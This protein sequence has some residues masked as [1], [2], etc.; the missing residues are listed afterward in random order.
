MNP[1][2]IGVN[3]IENDGYGPTSAVAHLVD[4]LNTA[5]APGTYAFIDVD[6][7]TSQVDA[8]G[9]DAIKVGL[10]YKPASVTPVGQTAALNTVAFVNGGDASP[11]NRASLAQAFQQNANGQV[12][13]VNVNHLK[14]K[15][16]ACTVPDAGD[17][18]G[19]CNVVRVNAVTEL[20]NWLAADPTGTGD[21]DILLVG[22]YNSYAMEDPIIA[23]ENGG[24]THLIKTLLGP[25]AYSYVF[26]G[27]WGY[28][29][30]A[31]GS[32]SIA[33]QISGV[34]DYHINSDEP[35]ALDYNTDFKT[36]NL[37]TIL[38]APNEFR[39]SDHD[40]V[41]VGLC[42]A[43][44][45]TAS[46]TPSVLWSPNHKYVNVSA[47]VNASSDTASITL[48]SVTSNE[49]DNGDDDGDTV[50]DIIIL[51]DFNFKLRA[52]RS[53]IGTGRIYTIT[54]LL[55]NT[56]GATTTVTV[57]VTVPLDQED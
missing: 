1:D 16:S 50:N 35:S 14:S 2:V 37:Q 42:Q 8:M 4:Q 3:E 5:T 38:Y 12:F 31:L 25:D 29:D 17:G 36:L 40:S 52:E 26:D 28:L 13:I 44:T 27:Q 32:A 9:T 47:A 39:V 30:H 51:D 6:A 20:M 11:R 45:G 19:N 43:P 10:I 55:T 53:G 54:Y 23:L 24:F 57:T 49:P 21:P 33:S 18:Q 22:D 34:G 41:I 7:N 15:G 48:V 56:C 46:A